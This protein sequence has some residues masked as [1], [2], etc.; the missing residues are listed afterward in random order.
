M[1]VADPAD[2]ASE[3][4]L[5]RHDIMAPADAPPVQQWTVHREASKRGKDVLVEAQ[6]V[7]T[8]LQFIQTSL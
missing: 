6:G 7:S 5:R 2:P 1:C 8:D 4:S 3:K